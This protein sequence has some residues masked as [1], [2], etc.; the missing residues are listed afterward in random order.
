SSEDTSMK[1]ALLA[2]WLP[3]CLLGFLCASIPL[4]VASR[5]ET[6]QGALPASKAATDLRQKINSGHGRERVRV[7]IQPASGQADELDGALQDSDASNVRQFHNLGFRVATMPAAAAA[8]LAAHSDV[9]Y[10]S[11]DHNVG[12]LGHVSLTGKLRLDVR[13]LALAHVIEEAIEVVRPA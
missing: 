6:K 9:A 8:A 4:S 2:L 5:A 3:V 1:R 13:P 12:G 11:L 10:V 7:I